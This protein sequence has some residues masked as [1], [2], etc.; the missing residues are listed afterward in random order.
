MRVS[1]GG[2]GF[3]WIKCGIGHAI[4]RSEGLALHVA[5]ANKDLIV[6]RAYLAYGDELAMVVLDETIFAPPIDLAYD[7]SI[8]DLVD[9]VETS[10]THARQLREDVL[11]RFGGQPFADDDWMLLA[12]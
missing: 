11:G 5:A 6:G 12:L 8:Q 10:M 4:P 3:L 9:R 7:P 1:R 2:N